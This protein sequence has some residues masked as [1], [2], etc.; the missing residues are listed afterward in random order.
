[1]TE[2]DGI[3]VHI[4]NAVAGAAPAGW[5]RAWV[6]AEVLPDHA[7]TEYD[8]VTAD[9]I[10]SWFDPG[11]DADSVV[12]LGLIDLLNMTIAAGKPAWRSVVLTV[13]ADGR[14]NISFKY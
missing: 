4:G 8:Y 13:H 5:Q 11:M 14:F 3:I 10:G 9:E 2:T 12:S 6:S 1:M 7:K